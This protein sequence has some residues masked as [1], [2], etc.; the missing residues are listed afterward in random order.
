MAE[1]GREKVLGTSSKS[2]GAREKVQR[3][4]SKHDRGLSVLEQ[5]DLVSENTYRGR[6]TLLCQTEQGLKMIKP[7]TGSVKRLEKINQILEHLK[8]AGHENLD[9]VLRNKEGSLIST[10]KDGITY[11]VKDWWDVLE[12][13]VRS[14]SDILSCM[15][16]LAHMHKN[17]YLQI[18]GGCEKEDLL[19]EY[20]KHNQQLKK[21]RVYIR[22]RKQ[23]NTFEY[24]YLESVGRYLEYGTK[25]CARLKEIGYMQMRAQDIEAG[26]ICHGMCNQHNFLISQEQAAL[27]N[28]DYFFMGNHMADVAQFLRKMMEKHNWNQELA[29]RM[30]DAY[31]RICPIT[32]YQWK[33]L[34]IRM[35]YPEKYWKISNFYYNNNKAFLPEKNMDK[36]N[37]F[38]MQ[39]NRWLN[40]LEKICGF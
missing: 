28:F 7:Y 12:C 32:Q 35:A 22:H 24:Q 13:D 27:V 17:M 38:I 16:Q 14:E 19:Q 30:L 31:D 20:E 29:R 2:P 25:A 1:N 3:T 40:F 37:Q 39:E 5:Y 21:I 6:G 23:K 11:L 36:L 26:S 8:E 10:D 9:M 34:G 33:L 18:E 15:Q 4:F